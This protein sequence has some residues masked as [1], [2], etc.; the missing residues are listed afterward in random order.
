M[1]GGDRLSVYIL[2]SVAKKFT[3][4]SYTINNINSYLTQ[5]LTTLSG[6][7]TTVQGDITTV[8]GIE[9]TLN[10]MFSE[11]NPKYTNFTALWYGPVSGDPTKDALGNPPI[12]GAQCYDTSVPIAKIYVGTSTDY[13][14]GWKP[15]DS[16][17]AATAAANAAAEAQA[18]ITSLN[19]YGL[20]YPSASNGNYVLTDRKSVV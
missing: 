11:F 17:A 8:Q 16:E 5:Q 3:T 6:L 18:A 1:I 13:P 7:V 20:V 19:G 9:S 12:V 15:Y 10:T 4:L 2:A 14:T